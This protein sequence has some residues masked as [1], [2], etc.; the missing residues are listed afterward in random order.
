MGTEQFEKGK[1][2]APVVKTMRG[3]ARKKTNM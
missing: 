2:D 1:A 3:Q